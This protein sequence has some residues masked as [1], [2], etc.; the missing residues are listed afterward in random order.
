[1]VMGDGRRKE[2]KHIS[3]IGHVL[4]PIWCFTVAV[5]FFETNTVQNDVNPAGEP[6]AGGLARML[7]QRLFSQP[8]TLLNEVEE[9]SP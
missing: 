4:Q 3:Y 8:T 1:M 5:V 7:S 6:A 9:I 2:A